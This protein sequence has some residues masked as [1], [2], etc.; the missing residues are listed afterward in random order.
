MTFFTSPQ[1][2]DFL[3]HFQSQ[4]G[5]SFQNPKLLIESFTHK[6]ALNGQRDRMSES[7]ERLEFLGD[8]VVDLILSDILM[9]EFPN[10][11]EGDLTKKRASLVNE[12]SLCEI[13]KSLGL[14][15]CIQLGRSELES[16]MNQN[17]RIL[18]SC[19][20]ALIG[21][22][23]LDGG[24][25]LTKKIIEALFNEKI[26]KVKAGVNAFEDFKTM[27]QEKLQKKY[28]MTPSYNLIGSEGPEHQKIFEVEV[29]LNGKVLAKANGRNKKLAEQNAAKIALEKIPEEML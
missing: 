8:A 23:Y 1:G 24:F 4:L 5:Y 6:S 21:A 20:E 19:F 22:L 25:A 12:L 18:A 14:E 2:L 16:G 15:K 3:V 27:L 10:E 29:M 17:Q 28:H 7:N 26:Q 11:A 13:A 9:N